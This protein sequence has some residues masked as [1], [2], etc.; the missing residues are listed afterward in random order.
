MDHI[1]TK[2]HQAIL[3]RIPNIKRKYEHYTLEQYIDL[4]KRLF[5]IYK[6]LD[7]TNDVRLLMIRQ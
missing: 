7:I 6:D 1:N 5:P 3:S 4:A 2:Y